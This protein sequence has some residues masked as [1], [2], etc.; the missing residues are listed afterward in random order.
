[1]RPSLFKIGQYARKSSNKRLEQKLEKE[2]KEA[3]PNLKKLNKTLSSKL[4]RL[5][6]REKAIQIAEDIYL[7][8]SGKIKVA[9]LLAIFL[10][11]KMKKNI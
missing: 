6:T 7:E 5:L 8:L 1:V 10:R 3:K 9:N 4:P 2:I 11:A